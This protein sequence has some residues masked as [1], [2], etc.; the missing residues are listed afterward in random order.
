MA[1]NAEGLAEAES[2]AIK[3]EPLFEI[4]ELSNNQPQEAV[5]EQRQEL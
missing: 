2:S 4:F 1:R 3:G 5:Q